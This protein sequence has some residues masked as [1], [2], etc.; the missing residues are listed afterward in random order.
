MRATIAT[1]GAAR[2]VCR[3]VCHDRS[4]VKICTRISWF[5]GWRLGAVASVVRRMNEVTLRRTRLVLGW[6]IVFGRV[7]H[8]GM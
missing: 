1:D 8:D 4:R 3:S 6:M 2:S 7:Y 5:L